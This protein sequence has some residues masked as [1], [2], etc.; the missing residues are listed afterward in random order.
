MI[1]RVCVCCAEGSSSE[2]KH[3]SKFVDVNNAWYHYFGVGDFCAAFC[4]STLNGLI[5]NYGVAGIY[6]LLHGRGRSYRAG[7]TWI[8]TVGRNWLLLLFFLELYMCNSYIM[9]LLLFTLPPSSL[10]RDG[11]RRKQ[12]ELGKQ[13]QALQYRTERLLVEHPTLPPSP[14]SYQRINIV[15]D[16]SQYISNLMLVG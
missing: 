6:L 13:L 3:L 8:S 15:G 10:G 4:L 7:C 5:W 11:S 2:P 16:C 12:K 9:T 1:H 14:F